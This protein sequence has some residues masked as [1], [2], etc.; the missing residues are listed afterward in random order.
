MEEDNCR[1][2]EPTG[3][4][5]DCADMNWRVV[6]GIQDPVSVQIEPGDETDS[7]RRACC[8]RRSKYRGLTGSH[9]DGL[10]VP[11]GE[12]MEQWM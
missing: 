1:L 2:E 4:R 3:E 6:W 11:K 10:G 9:R 12:G 8:A 5:E 7:E